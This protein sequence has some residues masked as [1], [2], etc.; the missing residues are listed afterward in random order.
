[1][2]YMIVL[3]GQFNWFIWMLTLVGILCKYQKN[4]LVWRHNLFTKKNVRHPIWTFIVLLLL[5]Q[6]SWKCMIIKGE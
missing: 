2:Q 4:N 6:L 5:K 3:N 1:M